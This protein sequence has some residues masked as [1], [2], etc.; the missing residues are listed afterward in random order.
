MKSVY[1]AGGKYMAS[2]GGKYKRYQRSFITL[3]IQLLALLVTTA[4]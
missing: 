3:Q 4:Y 2:I 1:Q